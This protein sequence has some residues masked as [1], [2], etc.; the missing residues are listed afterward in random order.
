MRLGTKP[1]P[2]LWMIAKLGSCM[3]GKGT[4]TR[5]I[6][7]RYEVNPEL[8]EDIEEAGLVYVGK[9]RDGGAL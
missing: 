8:I 3:E 2:S 1:T 6:E 9:G 7:H 5:G 4:S